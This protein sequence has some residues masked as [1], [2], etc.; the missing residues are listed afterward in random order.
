MLNAAFVVLHELAELLLILLAVLGCA[1]PSGRPSLRWVVS[2]SMLAGV[3]LGGTVA[4][5]LEGRALD[6]R[7]EAVLSIALGAAT[8]WMALNIVFSG[9][10]VREYVETMV[11]DLPTGLAGGASLAMLASFCAF[12][13]FRESMEVWIFLKH[14]AQNHEPADLAMGAA[15]G[16]AILLLVLAALRPRLQQARWLVLYR[17]STLGLCFV[18]VHLLLDDLAGLMAAQTW[19]QSHAADMLRASATALLAT[20]VPAMVL[21]RRWWRES[22]AV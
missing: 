10:S 1:S 20:S 16:A 11:E 13:G 21:A 15:I 5:V 8:L 14:A 22:S 7:F 4:A 2:G 6:V 19:L 12:A 17:L 3:V 18:A 9:H